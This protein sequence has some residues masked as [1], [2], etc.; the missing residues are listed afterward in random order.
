MVRLFALLMLLL[1][2]T[3]TMKA[4][5]DIEVGTKQS[6][7]QYYIPTYTYY[8][9]SLTQQ[10]YTPAEIGTAGTINAVSFYVY[11]NVSSGN[12]LQ[13]LI[14]VYMA[15]TSKNYF[16]SS[17]DFVT[18]DPTENL[19]FTEK[20]VTFTSGSLV[21]LTLD[22][23]FEYDGTSN[24]LI[25]VTDNS[26]NWCSSSYYAMKT[27]TYNDPNNSYRTIREF[28]DDNSFD[29]ANPY[30]ELSANRS[31]TT[32]KN[33]II[34][35]M[36]MGPAEIVADVDVMEL[37]ERPNSAYMRPGTFTL[38]NVGFKEGTITG[39]ESDNE[40]FTINAEFPIYLAP[41]A[42]V[43]IEVST[44]AADAGEVAGTF[45]VSYFDGSEDQTLEIGV[46]AT[47]YDPV[48]GDVWENPIDLG[49]L[50]VPSQLFYNLGTDYTGEDFPYHN[51]YLLP[52][53]SGDWQDYM[54][55]VVFKFTVEEDFVLDCHEYNGVR[56]MAVYDETFGGSDHPDIE[57]YLYND[58]DNVNQYM[59]AGT[60]YLVCDNSDDVSRYTNIFI[61]TV[62]APEI[63]YIVDPWEGKAG[64]DNGDVMSFN[65]G[66]YTKEMQVYV[67]TQYP[68]VT[69]LQ[70]WT[71]DLTAPVELTG[72]NH[73]TVYF[74]RLKTRND[75]GETWGNVVPFTTVL[76][77]V[78]DFAAE[79]TEI[80]IGDTAVFTWATNRAF[81]GYNFYQ[82]GVKLNDELLTIGTY[83]V[84][85][86]DYNPY[87]GYTFNVTAVYEAGE[88]AY[89]NN[90]VVRVGGYATIQ[91]HVY[92]Q[93]G[94]TPINNIEVAMAAYDEFGNTTSYI[95]TTDENGEYSGTFKAGHSFVISIN[96][97]RYQPAEQVI[98]G[99]LGNLGEM[100]DIDF[101]LD[102]VFLPVASVTAVEEDENV[103]VSWTSETRELHNYRVYRTLESNNGPYTLD[104]TDV[105]GTPTETTILD[106]TWSEVASGL[107]KYG[108][109][110][111]YEGNRGGETVPTTLSEGF[112]DG[113]PEGWTVLDADGDGRCWM[114]GSEVG[115]G[116]GKG[117]NGSHDMMISQSY[118]NGAT[119]YNKNNYLIT[120]KVKFTEAS[121]FS[122]WAC[123]QDADYPTET[124]GVYVSTTYNTY[125][126]AFVDVNSWTMTAKGQGEWYQYTVNLGNYAGNE[127]YVAICHY[128]TNSYGFYL[129]IDDVELSNPTVHV[130]RESEIV[131]SNPVGK[132][133]FIEN[134]VSVRIDLDSGENP[135]GA[136]IS[137][138]NNNE[139][140]QEH[141]PIADVT[142]TDDD[143]VY[144]EST[145]TY[146]G[147]Y[148]YESFRMGQYSVTLTRDHYNDAVYNNVSVM[149]ETELPYTLHEIPVGATMFA[150][151]PTGWATWEGV[152]GDDRSFVQYRISVNGT[153]SYTTDTFMQIPVSTLTEGNTYTCY[154]YSLYSSNSYS[155]TSTTFRY[156]SCGNYDGVDN[157]KLTSAEDGNTITWS[158][159][160]SETVVEELNYDSGS[161]TINS[162]DYSYFAVKFPAG[163]IQSDHITK[164][165]KY[166]SGNN[167]NKVKIFVYNGG[168]NSPEDLIYASDTV[169][170]YNTYSFE[171]YVFDEPLAIDNTQNLWIVYQKISGYTYQMPTRPNTNSGNNYVS[172]NG[173]DWTKF[174]YSYNI[175]IRVYYPLVLEAQ[176]VAIF[177]D[178]DFYDFTDDSAYTDEGVN[179]AHS[180]AVR[181]VYP[182][183][184]MSC[185][186]EA[187]YGDQDSQ[188]VEGWN[189]WSTY[190]EQENYDGLGI[191]E[192]VLGTNGLI[193]KSQ[194]GSVS[195]DEESGEWSGS[196]TS[197]NNEAMYKIKMSAPA[198]VT[199]YGVNA[200]LDDHPIT[201]YNGWTY[202][203]YLLRLNVNLNV[204]L[205]GLEATDGDMIKSQDGFA[206]YDAEIGEWFGSL[207]Y[208]EPT[209]GYMYKSLNEDEVTF[210]YTNGR[211]EQLG[212]NLT[213]GNNHWAADMHKYANNMNIMAGVE[214]DDEDVV[215]DY[216][217]AAFANGEC[218]G[219]V[220]LIYVPAM[221]RYVAFL[222]VAGD[223]AIA[224]TFALYNVETEEEILESNTT[225]MFN[226]NT[227][228]G[229]KDNPF[230]ISFRGTTNVS[231][232]SSSMTVY[233]NPVK[234]GDNVSVIMAEETTSM[235]V[236]VLNALGEVVSVET[237]GQSQAQVKMP[238]M[239]GVY[240][241][242]IMTN[243]NTH[244]RKVVVE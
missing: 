152:E 55:D 214:L 38:T 168:Q 65:F 35:N 79:N 114:L 75:S 119:V 164:V 179:D 37:G 91:G 144:D 239:P 162:Y 183:N 220:K 134:G 198:L 42:S 5:V 44:G 169:T 86:L 146:Y 159:P 34:L 219:S 224:L 228:L 7:G 154:L 178:G 138:V 190:I 113:L 150:V 222:T 125:A 212:E 124:F 223:E 155:Y 160:E 68:P 48:A 31:N 181:V 132:D 233:P 32:Y 111:V 106:E 175:M 56:M 71:S 156:K 72:L 128:G 88:S 182:G 10:I 230:V 11:S 17:T 115:L 203:G 77:P 205:E 207:S 161:G 6:T 36:D 1:T 19:V 226:A 213:S 110:C 209:K 171:D 142:L 232:Y 98:Y 201:L 54:K 39:I 236:E 197:I 76:D 199:M 196:L 60:Y 189:W 20:T 89:S 194:D 9:K 90:V 8:H 206:I 242:R 49:T 136:T 143:I 238:D 112:D 240:M 174:T 101:I 103:K 27:Y 210:T 23:P 74:A 73:N 13:R 139:Y 14:S 58:E 216:E 153:N 61:N 204:A 53:E 93:D 117:H 200:E 83:T 149:G 96:D 129:D 87:T 41:N 105:I 100:T 47:A 24:L 92:E 26:T 109:S 127:G 227:M 84:E 45:T 186:T 51:I 16:S 225:A 122:F 81:L 94:T 33:Y 165:S 218:R 80:W 177:R 137:F 28:R 40:Y 63:S 188:L 12:G 229:E 66:N 208:F 133:M 99:S 221:N 167:I 158:Y 29:V 64:V 185:E 172:S 126:S 215:G 244:F 85:N 118:A 57:N 97:E 243:G 187:S 78:D 140:E 116:Y 52:D 59:M 121:E 231:E 43:D 173:I 107:Y 241:V 170:M 166:V 184:L 21:T 108:V 217:L 22:T 15:N 195:Y 120:P 18:L 193:I 2:F 147:Y 176:G 25:C 50:D 102:E 46:T 30:D 95:F 234:K 163:S 192:T 211:S 180:Y 202:F 82:D 130:E 148:T 157:M 69:L 235:Q 191:L 237:F 3:G 145:E 135:V 4:G 123:A 141:Y 70:D 104:N 131:W 67:G 62:P 151:S